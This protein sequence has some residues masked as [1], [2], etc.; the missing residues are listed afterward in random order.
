M[1]KY[2]STSSLLSTIGW[3]SASRLVRESIQNNTRL[4]PLHIAHVPAPENLSCDR[5]RRNLGMWYSNG[6][7][8]PLC[9]TTN[10]YRPNACI[11]KLCNQPAT[12]N[13]KTHLQHCRWLAIGCN[14]TSGVPINMMSINYIVRALYSLQ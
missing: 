1:S 10:C 2:A 6:L 3:Q 14:P 11:C 12:K 8:H 9:S 13:D 7:H 4:N 5:T